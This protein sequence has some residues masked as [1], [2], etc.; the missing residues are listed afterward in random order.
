MMPEMEEGALVIDDI[1]HFETEA[2]AGDLQPDVFCA[3]IKEKYAVQ[4]AGN[5]LQTASQ[6]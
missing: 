6:L 1:Y 3:G 5:P 2:L 4:K